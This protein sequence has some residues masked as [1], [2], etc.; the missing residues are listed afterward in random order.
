MN[1]NAAATAQ[2]TFTFFYPRKW[3][4]FQFQPE[5]TAVRLPLSFLIIASFGRVFSIIAFL[6]IFC[7]KVPG[8]PRPSIR[9]PARNSPYNKGPA[10]REAHDPAASP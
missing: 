9:K 5:K 6:G 1:A 7:P 8:S 2:P 3:L 10:L 4:R